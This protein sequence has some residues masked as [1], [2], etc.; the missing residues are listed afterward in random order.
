LQGYGIK[1][2]AEYWRQTMPKSMGCVFWQYN[3]IW[4]GMSWSSVDYFGRWKALHFMA[5]KFY[6][7]ILVSGLENTKDGTVDVFVTNDLLDSHQGKLRWKITDLTGRILMQDMLPVEIP[8]RKSVNVKTLDLQEQIKES[9]MN[10]FLTWLEL[11]VQGK[12]V[13]DNLVLFALPKEYK[14]AN[15]ALT[16]HV[17]DA[18]DGFLVAVKAENPALWVWLGLEN[19]DAKYSD[20]FVHLTPDTP[21]RILIK[22]WAGLSKDDFVKQLQVRSLFDTYSPV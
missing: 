6:S 18:A 1:I 4:P 15:P 16:A 19:A 20:N 14:L 7:P 11:E 8:S 13:S 21:K 22:P 10:G 2:G 9:G 17:D 5:R 12:T 3:D